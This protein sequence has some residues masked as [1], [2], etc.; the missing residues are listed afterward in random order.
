MVDCGTLE[1]LDLPCLGLAELVH[2]IL[3]AYGPGQAQFIM[4]RKSC[5][6]APGSALSA[7]RPPL[8][9]FSSA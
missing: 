3:K 6:N 7:P 4:P 5:C 1:C 2:S 8:D 9:H